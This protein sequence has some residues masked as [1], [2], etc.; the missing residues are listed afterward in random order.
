MVNQR[1]IDL[2]N[3]AL[4]IS[5]LILL[6]LIASEFF[7]RLDFTAEK[8]YTLSPITKSILK[9]LKDQVQITVYLEG[10]FPAGFKRL[11]NS[12]ED[13]LRDFDSYAGKNFQFDFKEKLLHA[14]RNCLMDE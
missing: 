2:R 7:T 3:L 8:R 10:E 9:D 6:N 5:A 11:R 14:F 13:L 12:T 1:K 4:F